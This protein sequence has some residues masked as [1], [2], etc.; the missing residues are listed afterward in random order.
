MWLAISIFLI[1]ISLVIWQPRQLNIGI[2]ASAGALAAL[3]TGVIHIADIPIVWSLI[4]NATVTFIGIIIISALMDEAGLFEWA[5][6]HVARWGKGHAHRLFVYII[7]L[8]AVVSA[9]FANDGAALILTPIV[10]AIL[11]ALGF[12][13]TT[14]LAFVMAA[15]FIADT[16]STALI[17]SNLTNIVSADFFSLNFSQYAQVMLPVNAVAVLSSLLVLYVFY[18][19][20]LPQNYALQQLK[21]PKEAIKD[22]VSFI[23]GIAVLGFLLL[24]FFVIEPLGVPISLLVALATVILVVIVKRQNKIALKPILVGAPWHIVIFSLGMYLVVYGLRN[25]GLTDYLAQLLNQLAT[26][27]IW[28]V[29]LGTGFLTAALSSV[30]NNL[31]SVL[32]G[33]L[34]ID[35]SNAEGVV[36]ETMI[37]ANVIG[38]DLGTKFTPIGS[39]ATLLWLHILQRKHIYISW[40]YYMKVGVILTTPVL[41]ISLLALAWVIS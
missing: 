28:L 14:T 31:P 23:V 15:G 21:A 3:L 40:G 11:Y 29:S 30:M 33:A 6:L 10:I 4:W 1:T 36:R 35:A 17:V 19:K 16:A 26:Q 38:S 9:L 18:R 22:P 5:A 39:L 27:D 32:I 13:P 8:G 37:Y 24:A 12:S 25:A 2:T 34:A 7:L 41:A 20:D